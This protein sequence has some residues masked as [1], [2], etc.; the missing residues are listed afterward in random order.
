MSGIR[1]KLLGFTASIILL[2]S[3]ALTSLSILEHRDQMLER[4]Q[5]EARQLF[6]TL[7]E[8]L[9]NP[10]YR[11]DL[12]SLRSHLAAMRK[13]RDVAQTLLLDP[14]GSIL[15]DGTPENS[16]FGLPPKDPFLKNLL[17]TDQ[18]SIH[19]DSDSLWI[20]GALSL[21]PNKSLGW[22]AINFSLETLLQKLSTHLR[23][24]LLVASL[25]V[26]IGLLLAYVLSSRFTHPI[27]TLTQTANRICS[28]EDAIEIPIIGQDEILT[29]SLALERMLAQIRTS[30]SELQELNASLDKKV[31][32]RT[33][34]LEL[35]R[36]VAIEAS[37]AKSNFLASM[38]HEIRTP[39]N[40]I[41]G[42]TELVME[43]DQLPGTAREH[44]RI[45]LHAAR[46]LLR[47]INDILD[48]SKIE[49]GRMDLTREPFR[50]QPMLD[51]L[52]E[53]F[54]SR[55]SEKGLSLRVAIAPECQT[56]LLG[57]SLRLEQI[58]M[59]LIGNAIKFTETGG[60]H[61]RAWSREIH[62]HRLELTVSVQDTGIGM[63]RE[64]CARLFTPFSQADGSISRRYGGTGLG[65]AISKKLLELM[66]GSIHV[67]SQVGT[68]T[69]FRFFLECERT[70]SSRFERAY[71]PMIA[72][73][74]GAVHT[75][76]PI[77]YHPMP[78]REIE[79]ARDRLTGYCVLLV[80]DN[81]VNTLIANEIL[82]GVGLAVDCAVSG[83]EA[84]RLVN[85]Q[86]H[87]VVLMDLQ[88]PDMDGLETTRRLRKRPE[89]AHLPI[90]AMTAHA[91][92]EDRDR[93]LAAG[94]DDHVAKPFEPGLLFRTLADWLARSGGEP[95]IHGSGPEHPEET[96]PPVAGPA[97]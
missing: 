86:R 97:T 71:P 94:M 59:N 7:S 2:V 63:S 48:Y 54:R 31:E 32:E 43:G 28:G 13:H 83:E 79:I 44:L 87:A 78:P 23:S 42:L 65:L 70:A 25:C 57:D 84:L 81:R 51:H 46:S 39:M 20:G 8:S 95:G 37:Q 24:Q 67:E 47:I 41:I 55:L 35:A 56:T 38:S 53:L 36:K 1:F 76:S 88:M 18:L 50:L 89:L 40:A 72:A 62:A 77:A 33:A 9:L 10:L 64:Q 93:C 21:E 52:L 73:A 90:I 92:R 60:I 30:Q 4:H 58:L 22:L 6:A 85:P 45:A 74:S 5:L 26:M 34:E 61:V 49:A 17:L 29:L 27:T 19:I 75:D 96:P 91:M 66:G 14:A 68:G 80:E 69:T 16:S 12:Q 3:A 15:A 82:K 11:L